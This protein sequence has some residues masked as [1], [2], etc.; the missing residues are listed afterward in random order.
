MTKRLAAHH[1]HAARRTRHLDLVK[2]DHEVSRCL[3]STQG[4]CPAWQ[5]DSFCEEVIEVHAEGP[6]MSGGKR[7]VFGSRVPVDRATE[8][9]QRRILVSGLPKLTSQ[10]GRE[11]AHAAEVVG[12][13]LARTPSPSSC[14]GAPSSTVI[15]ANRRNASTV[16]RTSTTVTASG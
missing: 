16:A 11:L 1:S 12:P 14:A 8:L 3:R 2:R 9:P 5:G 6:K 10:I 13:E 7:A 4:P 15:E